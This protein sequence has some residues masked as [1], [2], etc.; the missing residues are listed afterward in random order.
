MVLL[1]D[2]GSTDVYLNPGVYEPGKNSKNLNDNFTVTFATI[3][4]DGS[5]TETVRSALQSLDLKGFSQL[6]DQ[7]PNLSGPCSP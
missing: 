6:T 4:S 5:G 2:T 1:I 3:N 7:R